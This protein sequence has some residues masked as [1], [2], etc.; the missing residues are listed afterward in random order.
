MHFRKIFC[1]M[2]VTS[3]QL[4]AFVRQKGRE[5]YTQMFILKTRVEETAWEA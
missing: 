3:R 4:V 2:N 1:L 5:K